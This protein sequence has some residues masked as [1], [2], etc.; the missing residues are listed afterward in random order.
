MS[1]KNRISADVQYVWMK[2][3][4]RWSGEDADAFHREYVVKI[5]E[6]ADSFEDACSKL[7]RLSAECIKELK[8]IEQTLVD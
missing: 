4:T 1:E 2:L 6:I 5:S 8:S 7:S 3:N